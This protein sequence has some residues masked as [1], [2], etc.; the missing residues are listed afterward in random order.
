MKIVAALSSHDIQSVYEMPLL[1]LQPHKTLWVYK[2]LH[3]RE[4]VS[5]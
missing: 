3:V 2:L 5:N 4:A 1:L